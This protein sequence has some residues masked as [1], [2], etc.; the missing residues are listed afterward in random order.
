M[1]LNKLLKKIFLTFFQEKD[2]KRE[3]YKLPK[4]RVHAFISGRVQGVGFRASTRR[5]ANRLG[6]K[7]WV[8][9]LAD[10][11]V[12]VVAEGEKDRIEKFIDFL[13]DGPSMA[14]VENVQITEERNRE[15]F[16]SFSIRF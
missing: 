10:G 11:R 13:H 2:Q 3:W 12:E 14:R 8:K 15:E 4:K 9:N 5:V 6:V 7:G 1:I 16:E